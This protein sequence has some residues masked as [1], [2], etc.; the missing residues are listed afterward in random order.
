MFRLPFTQ[1][2][3]GPP[4]VRVRPRV[5]CSRFPSHVPV[6]RRL[7]ARSP[8]LSPFSLYIRLSIGSR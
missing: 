2:L 8:L 6:C 3:I 1:F 7:L 5:P 4:R